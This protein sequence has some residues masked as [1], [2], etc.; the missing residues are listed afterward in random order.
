M[1][2][3]VTPHSLFIADL[4]LCTSRT[5]TSRLFFDFL[6]ETAVHA[7]ALYIL[8]DLFEYWLGDDS[9]DLPLHQQVCAALSR[10]GNSGVS[11]YFMHGNR[12]FLLAGQFANACHATL[13][14]DPTLVNLYGTSSLLMHGDTLCTDDVGYLAF[15]KQVRDPEWQTQFLAQPLDTRI[16]VAQQARSQSEAAKQEKTAAIMDVNMATVTEVLRQYHYPRLIHG[17]THRPALHSIDIDGHISQ[18]WVLADWYE[19]GGYLRCDAQGCQL[20]NLG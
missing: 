17:H 18:R 3:A 11:I 19:R 10:L 1:I 20:L 16:A 6:T 9:L 13:L 4:H 15:R 8:G 7:E 5:A 12:D 14:A 2:T